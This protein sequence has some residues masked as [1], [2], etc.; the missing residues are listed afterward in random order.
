MRDR[1]PQYDPSTSV[2]HKYDDRIA[3]DLENGALTYLFS[4]PITDQ[5]HTSLSFDLLW[6]GVVSTAMC[7]EYGVSINEVN[8]AYL[9]SDNEFRVATLRGHSKIIAV[10]DDPSKL[11]EYLTFRGG[12]LGGESS[13][14]GCP[15]GCLQRKQGCEIKG[16]ISVETG[17]KI[18]HI[19][20][21]EWYNETNISPEYG[22]RW[23]CTEEEARANGWRKAYK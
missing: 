8:Y 7:K 11:T 18:Y 16:N 10:Y 13:S 22:E 1:P 15:N 6:M 20:G 9:T 4:G 21:Q 3:V 19:P 23:F 5:D 17:E 14:T 2:I 12:S